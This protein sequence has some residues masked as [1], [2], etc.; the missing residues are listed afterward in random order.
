MNFARVIK[1]KSTRHAGIAVHV[2][3]VRKG[4]IGL[5]TMKERYC[6]EGQNIY[7]MIILKSI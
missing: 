7:F 2:R 4:Q 3:M 5:E 6:L 1:G